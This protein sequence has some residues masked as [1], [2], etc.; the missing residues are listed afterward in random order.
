MDASIT[1]IPSEAKKKLFLNQT[2]VK[3]F[4]TF[5]GVLL[6]NKFNA[7]RISK[8]NTPCPS[9]RVPIRADSGYE[10]RDANELVGS[11]LASR[12]Y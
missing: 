1:Y 6:R 9:G 3:Q 7:R 8:R 10:K 2:L 5:S 12:H 11:L 4:G